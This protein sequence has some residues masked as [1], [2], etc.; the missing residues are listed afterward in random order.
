MILAVGITVLVLIHMLFIKLEERVPFN[1]HTQE[2][3]EPQK[4]GIDIK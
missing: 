3:A 4:K 1:A 2:Q